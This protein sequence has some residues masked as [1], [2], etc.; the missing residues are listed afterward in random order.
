MTIGYTLIA[1]SSNKEKNVYDVLRKVQEV[2]ESHQLMGEYDIISKIEAPCPED[3]GAIII[4][5]IRPIDGV[6]Y[7][8]T[9]CAINKN[10][11]HL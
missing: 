1:V 8:K 3:M 2:K 9:L 10:I 11:L 6:I 7:T 5:K 4:D